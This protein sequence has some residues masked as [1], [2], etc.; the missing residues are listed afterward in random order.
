[1]K[2]LLISQSEVF[3][4]LQIPETKATKAMLNRLVKQGDII[5]YQFSQ[6]NK[7]YDE[8]SIA[9]FIERCRVSSDHSV[10]PRKK[11]A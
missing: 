9:N 5:C 2:T 6:K 4:R 10:P 1:M 8:Q 7:S 3:K 11:V